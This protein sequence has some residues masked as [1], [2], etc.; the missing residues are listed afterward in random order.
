MIESYALQAFG[1]RAFVLG[2]FT[3]IFPVFAL[4]FRAAIIYT[5]Y[6]KVL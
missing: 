5:F 4:M 6:W 3:T 2:I 1:K